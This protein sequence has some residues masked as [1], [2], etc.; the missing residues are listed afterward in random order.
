LPDSAWGGRLSS[1]SVADGLA[2]VTFRQGDATLTR[3]AFISAPDDVPAVR[4]KTDKLGT[5]AFTVSLTRKSN[6]TITAPAD[7]QLHLDGQI[8]DVEKKD[9]GYDGNAGGSGPGGAHMRFAGRLLVRVDRG[10]VAP[11][12]PAGTQ[13]R[14]HVDESLLAA[15]RAKSLAA[16]QKASPV[17]TH[18]TAGPRLPTDETIDPDDSA[19]PRDPNRPSRD[20]APAAT[21]A[22]MLPPPADPEDEADPAAIAPAGGLR[23]APL[24]GQ[25]QAEE[26]TS[27]PKTAPRFRRW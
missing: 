25:R 3:E 16:K 27:R 13:P 20:E 24:G 5:L 8:V 10:K 14:G 6:A 9:G 21:P 7:D 23:P 4:V 17:H 26:S 18:T 15:A 22:D 19:K 11:A 1:L 2:R 12:A